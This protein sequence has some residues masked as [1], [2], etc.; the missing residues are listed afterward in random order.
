MNES[1]TSSSSP[2][3][4]IEDLVKEFSTSTGPLRVLDKI[5]LELE[6]GANLAVVGPSGSG[7]STFLYIVGTLDQPSA[8]RILL[9]GQA[10]LELSEAELA[11]FRNEKIGF[12]FQAHHLLPQLS[13]L[14]NVLVPAI[15]AQKMSALSTQRAEH[16]LEQVGLA[17]RMTH[18]PGQLSGGERQ[19]VAVARALLNSP[20]L[21]L[22]DEPTGS[23]DRH[24]A[25]R[26]GELLLDL[27]QQEN[28]MLV[29]V[30]HNDQLANQ[31]SKK[32]R[33]D[34]GKFVSES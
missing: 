34:Q 2:A 22:A 31:F 28:V 14:E 8:G 23:L 12:I 27:Q 26:I 30:T 1:S 5:S 15:A 20:S 25:E 6:Q 9:H 32:V 19:R 33:L 29:C 24:N 16:L 17:D 18:V 11:K 13:A 21:V 10:P 7:K 4:V 3:L